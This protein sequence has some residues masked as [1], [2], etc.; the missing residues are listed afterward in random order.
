MAICC[1]ALFFLD[2]H[3][4]TLLF[5]N[6]RNIDKNIISE[7]N[8]LFIKNIN[9]NSSPLLKSD[10][11]TFLYLIFENI[12]FVAVL[13]KNANVLLSYTFLQ[14]L[15]DL[16]EAYFTVIN[17][18]IINNNLLLI[19]EIM[20]EVMDF[21]F[22]QITDAEI[23]MEY[24]TQ[25]GSQDK[26]VK[27]IPPA[28]TNYVSWRAHNTLHEFNNVNIVINESVSITINQSGKAVNYDVKGKIFL[29][30]SLSGMPDITIKLCDKFKY[31]T[32]GYHRKIQEKKSFFSLE[33]Y[34]L[35]HC[36]DIRAF[37]IQK[38]LKFIPP[39][40][41]FELMSYHLS[42]NINFR[43][44]VL[45]TCNKRLI[46]RCKVIYYLQLKTNYNE[47]NRADYINIILPVGNE[48][49]SPKFT[50]TSGS[51]EHDTKNKTVMWRLKNIGGLKSANMQVEFL[52]PSITSTDEQ[53]IPRII[54]VHFKVSGIL[55]SGFKIK[56]FNVFERNYKYIVYPNVE[57]L[58]NDG[59]YN[60]R[61]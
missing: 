2:A 32:E 21:G 51:V 58:V 22:P 18:D 59:V 38:D 42:A 39:E 56:N 49:F 55:V 10:N 4:N 9:K 8:Y 15:N 1:S 60:I 5:K 35:H 57:Y 53:R 16:L 54:V 48:V 61:Y 3:R 23:L 31:I 26:S 28:V 29:D 30:V 44:I 40:G 37:E 17:I 14:K 24:V 50:K 20:D 47:N 46:G 13:E 36:V 45:V 19:Y 27:R 52:L 11:F 7:F 33:A 6:Y 41:I 25:Y 34:N 12:F 43:P